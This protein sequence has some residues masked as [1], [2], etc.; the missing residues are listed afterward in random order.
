VAAETA[1][2]LSQRGAQAFGS[3][4]QRTEPSAPVTRAEDGISAAKA[5]GVFDV[6]RKQYNLGDSPHFM[7]EDGNLRPRDEAR[8][9][10]SPAPRDPRSPQFGAGAPPRPAWGTGNA[11]NGDSSRSPLTQ[12]SASDATRPWYMPAITPEDLDPQHFDDDDDAAGALSGP[13]VRPE[14]QD[15]VYRTH[16]ESPPKPG[17]QD[18]LYRFNGNPEEAK[19]HN[20]G[21]YQN[22]ADKSKNPAPQP[23]SNP[24]K[25]PNNT[26]NPPPPPKPSTTRLL[27]EGEK[28]LVK[29]IF[30]DSIKDLDKVEIR[31]RNFIP[32]FQRSDTTMTP[33][34]NMYPAKDLRHVK[35]FSKERLEL[36]AH[37]IHEMTHVWQKQD[38]MSVKTRGLFSLMVPYDY[39]Y[40]PGK[41]FRKYRLE[42]QATMIADYFLA[43]R[44]EKIRPQSDDGSKW[45]HL[46]TPAEYEALIPWL[47]DLRK[48][49]P[50]PPSIP[51]P[52]PVP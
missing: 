21:F 5:S 50:K 1:G 9:S 42:Q 16:G 17:L 13:K 3:Q 30:G 7:D 6:V 41:D 20:S 52:H 35:D 19:D 46:R 33:N 37:L 23:P 49:A 24:P 18:L 51:N 36:Q 25:D 8:Q 28:Q 43:L 15:L 27:T 29:S 10:D 38:G 2:L 31:N 48:S 44:G 47:K 26:T 34:G 4:F 39:K 32:F 11:A 40:E 14:V 45:F 22:V 12:P